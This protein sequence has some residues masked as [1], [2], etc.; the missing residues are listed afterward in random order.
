MARLRYHAE[1]VAAALV[2]TF[3]I[4]FAI[5]YL[6]GTSVNCSGLIV[7]KHYKPESVH[8]Y[9]RTRTDSKGRTRSYTQIDRDPAEWIIFVQSPDGEVAKVDCSSEV[10]Y[11]KEKGQSLYFITRYGGITRWP[12][13]RT[14]KY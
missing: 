12:L 2:I 10:Y 1:T 6:A 5:D 4:F 3:I 9:L 14:S 8:V 13:T 7:E 11:S